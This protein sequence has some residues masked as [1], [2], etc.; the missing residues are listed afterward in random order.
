MIC[1]DCDSKPK[2]RGLK[3]IYCP[4]CNKEKVAGYNDI[5]CFDCSELLGV[6]IMCHKVMKIK[7][8]KV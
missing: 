7:G 6:C 8:E 1:A 4:C 5:I 2:V 3:N